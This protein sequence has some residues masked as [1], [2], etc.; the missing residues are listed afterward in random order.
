MSHRC[1]SMSFADALRTGRDE[2]GSHRRMRA[3]PDSDAPASSTT[4]PRCAQPLGVSRP[5]VSD[6]MGLVGDRDLVAHPAQIAAGRRVPYK[7]QM[8]EA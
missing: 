6:A 5:G 7:R 1:S 8:G 3:L 2:H 4:D